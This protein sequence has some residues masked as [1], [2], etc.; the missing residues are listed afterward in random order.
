MT[1]VDTFPLLTIDDLLDQLGSAKYFTILDLAAR[2]W[3]IRVADNS[4]EK[5]APSGLFE[6]CVMPFG[7]INVPAIFQWLMQ[8]VLSGLNPAGGPDFVAV[9]IDDILI[10]SQSM[11]EHLCHIA[12]VLEQLHTAGLKLK[13]GKCYFLCQ[14][15]EYLGASRTG[16]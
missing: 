2:Y 7:L 16:T 8:C 9:Y 10:S 3:Q 15:V 13:P 4:I 12:Q 5:T 1:K 14:R 11:E 6:F